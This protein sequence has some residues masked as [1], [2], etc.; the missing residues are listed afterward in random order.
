MKQAEKTY[1]IS[2]A[3]KRVQVESH[4]LRYWEEELKLPI[5][6]NEMGHRYYTEDDIRRFQE[7]RDLKEQGLQ[8]KAI[9]NVL[10]REEQEGMKRHVVMVNKGEFMPVPEESREAKSLRLQQLLQNMIAE[11]VRSNNREM[12]D[13]IKESILKELD[14]QFRQQEEREEERDGQQIRRQEEY[15][16]QLD[17]LLRVRSKGKRWEK[18]NKGSTEPSADEIT[19]FAQ[20]RKMPEQKVQEVCGQAEERVPSADEKAGKKKGG[21]FLSKK[22]SIV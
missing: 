22:R 10:M 7:V 1:L 14:Y 20:K 11:A 2:D 15:Y 4:V 12:C 18:K 13:D 9:R 8:L 17:E 5:K 16:R 3:A 6:R 19:L 21:F